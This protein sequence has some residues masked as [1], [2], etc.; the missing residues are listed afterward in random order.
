[1]PL[2]KKNVET[3]GFTFDKVK[4]LLISHAHY[5]HCAGSALIK[6]MTGA[7]YFV[8]D[9]DAPLVESGGKMDYQYGAD[10]AHVFSAHQ[11][12]PRAA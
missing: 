11:S 7:K 1:M 4:I 2:I 5:D 6:Q 8:M 9:A 12:R 3:L 10:A